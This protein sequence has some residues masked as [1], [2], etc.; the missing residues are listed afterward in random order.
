V[1]S[2]AGPVASGLDTAACKVCAAIG[3][4][5]IAPDTSSASVAAWVANCSSFSENRS[6]LDVA[7]IMNKDLLHTN[8]M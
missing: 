7:N 6:D 5:P 2:G 1:A 8:E 3:R 4:V